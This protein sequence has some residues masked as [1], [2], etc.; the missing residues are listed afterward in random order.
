MKK[1]IDFSAN[2]K[3]TTKI[4]ID[5]SDCPTFWVCKIG[6]FFISKIQLVV[7]YQCCVLIG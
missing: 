6:I 4:I 5:H 1:K 2:D 7:Y 3:H